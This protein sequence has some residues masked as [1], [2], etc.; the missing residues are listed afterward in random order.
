MRVNRAALLSVILIAVLAFF[1]YRLWFE[2]DG[3]LDV[4]RLKK[5]LAV[6]VKK[7]EEM[8]QHNAIL[9]RQVEYLQANESAVESR[10]RKELGM[11]KKDETFY[12][13]VK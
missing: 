6:E 1:Q 5:Q 10:A 3:L 2:Q 4:F 11:I 12:H 7:N 9:K 8:K 13:V